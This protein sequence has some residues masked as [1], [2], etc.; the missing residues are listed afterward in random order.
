M[1]R[2]VLAMADAPI[3][4][5][6]L[7]ALDIHANLA[8]KVTFHAVTAVDHFAK[9]GYLRFGQVPHSRVRIDPACCQDLLAGATA[10]AKDVGQSHCNLFVSWQVYARNT[11]HFPLPVLSL[12]LFVFR[13][14][15]DDTQHPTPL[16]DF[17]LF[18]TPLD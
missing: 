11:S 5:D 9:F 12:A 3:A 4:A 2:Q 18:T 13:V 15:A 6:L 14:L 8:P 16:D 17:A 1:H 7:Q 10:N